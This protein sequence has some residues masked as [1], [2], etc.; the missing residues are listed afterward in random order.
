MTNQKKP[1]DDGGAAF[2]THENAAD[3]RT[4][5]FYAIDGMSLWDY[6]A[7]HGPMR[8]GTHDLSVVESRLTSVAR[9]NAQYADAM[10]FEKRKRER[11][12]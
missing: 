3:P 8:F 12:E 6:F 9:L 4:D 1:F 5:G 10:I 11:R 2:P 7:A